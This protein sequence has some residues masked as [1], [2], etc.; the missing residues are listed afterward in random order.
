MKFEETNKVPHEAIARSRNS[1]Y[2]VLI[3][4]ALLGKT[5]K[6]IPDNPKKAKNVLIALR[7]RIRRYKF[8]VS[9]GIGDDG[10]VYVFPQGLL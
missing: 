5:S 6:I 10:A 9:C 3:D 1:K 4:A 8:K 7:Y 2:Q